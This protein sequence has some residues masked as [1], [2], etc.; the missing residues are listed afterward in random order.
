MLINRMHIKYPFEW[1]FECLRSVDNLKQNHHHNWDLT[2]LGQSSAGTLATAWCPFTVPA[3]SFALGRGEEQ[4][5]MPISISRNVMGEA[6][7]TFD[8]KLPSACDMWLGGQALT[9]L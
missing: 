2:S 7:P 8:W 9:H 3:A 4:V 5:H 6:V 1:K